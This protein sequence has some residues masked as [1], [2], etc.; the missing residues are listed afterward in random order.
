MN[1]RWTVRRLQFTAA[2][3]CVVLAMVVS[4]WASSAPDGLERVAQTL[5][6]ESA[7]TAGAAESSPLAGYEV[8]WLG[9]GRLS[10]ALAGLVGLV[11]VALVMHL[12][13][14]AGR[15]R[16]ALQHPARGQ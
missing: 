5:G 9:G 11:V 14:R 12:L 1:G 13:V 4:G 3:V 16:E 10:G 2:L 8:G 7:G 15:R 6:F